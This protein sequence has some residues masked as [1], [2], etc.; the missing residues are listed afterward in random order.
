MRLPTADR[1]VYWALGVWIAFG[2]VNATQIVVGMRAEGMHHAWASLFG[3]FSL[4]W[5]VW[6]AATPVVLALGKRIPLGRNAGWRG[7]GIH[8]AACVAI[9]AAHAMWF[10]W[11]YMVL[12]PMGPAARERP[13]AVMAMS[14]FMEEFHLDLI[15]Y[16]AVLAVGY[17]VESRRRLAERE[18]EAER[19]GAQLALA[20]LDALR[21]Q[22]EPHFLFNTL[23]GI[24]ALARDN[25][26][27][28]AVGM[29]AGLSDLLRRV[30]EGAE[31]QEAPLGEELEFVERYLEIQQMRFAERLR[32]VMDIPPELYTARVPSLI[33][34][35]IVENA[36][37]HGIG[38]RVEGGAIRIAA[39]RSE[40]VLTM[41]VENDGPALANDL[42]GVSAGIGIPNS[43]ARLKS[44]Y[45]DAAAL[46]V[47]NRELGGV[48]AVVTLP[49]RTAIA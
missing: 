16:A 30:V 33:L 7:Y 39:S 8:F 6:A 15:A 49:Y 19:L 27:N 32:I 13:F 44:L 31:R 23:N 20:R 25:R 37:Q 12:R 24:A 40:T 42:S 21:R 46:D 9:G 5:L 38:R 28:A 34:Q 2:L 29:I 48:E 14:C 22:L 4:T 45:G 11:L 47:R 1:P 26:N 43:R 36:I 18:L 35:P 17:T 10:A 41:R 3:V